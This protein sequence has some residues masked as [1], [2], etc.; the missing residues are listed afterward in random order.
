MIL[1][2]KKYVLVIET[3]YKDE[4]ITDVDEVAKSIVNSF[5]W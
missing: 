5:K 3:D 1:T 2:Q 4:N